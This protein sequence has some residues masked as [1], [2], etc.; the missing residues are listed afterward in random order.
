MARLYYTI[1]CYRSLH[2]CKLC[3][4]PYFLRRETHFPT[5]FQC[6]YV[7]SGQVISQILDGNIERDKFRFNLIIYGVPN[8]TSEA[9]NEFFIT[10]R[11]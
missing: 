8:S 11:L 7:G 5:E 9:I 10:D 2:R 6:I 3:G 4:L 1:H